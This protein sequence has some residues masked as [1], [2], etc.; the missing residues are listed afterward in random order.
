MPN[1]LT[2]ILAGGKGTRL[3]PLTNDRA[4]PSVPFAGTFRIIDFPL[5]NCLNSNLR[6]I[7]VLTQYKAASLDRHIRQ[8]WH[9]LCRELNEFIDVLPPQQ[10]LGEHWYRGTADAVYQNIYTI[11]QHS[12]EHILILA[13]DHI[14]KMDYSEMVADHLENNADCTIGCLRVGMEEGRSFG[15][16]GIDEKYWVRKFVEKP[17][18]PFPIPGDPQRCL[19]SMGIY[20]FKASFLLNELCRDATVLKSSH[21][22]GKDVIPKLIGTHRVRAFPFQDRN[23]GAEYYWR[24]VGTLDAYYEAQMDLIAVEPRLN[25]YDYTWPIR[26]Y[27]P[28]LPPPKFVFADSESNPPRVGHALDSIVCPGCIISG[29]LVQRSVLSSNVRVNSWATV[30]DSILFEGV[31]VGRH[32]VV[33]RAIIDKEVRI[34]PHTTIGVSPEEDRERGFTVTESGL[35]VVPKWHSFLEQHT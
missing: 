5:S 35:T 8:A 9:F 17:D 30:T 21:D 1:V 12:P 26:G 33:R 4:K 34:P 25:M 22:F 15:V 23:S 10:R 24:D 16:M 31:N 13:G 19:A 18:Q 27:H 11:E 29:G 14:Y 20:I 6:R 32:S 3:E 28:P 2:L 7:L